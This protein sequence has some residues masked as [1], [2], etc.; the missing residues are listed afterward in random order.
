MSRQYKLGYCKNREDLEKHIDFLI[1]DLKSREKDISI[2]WN[3]SIYKIELKATI[4]PNEILSWEIVKH[5]RAREE[6]NEI[7]NK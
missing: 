4:E 5:Y 6:E 7:S 1:E 2:D 3:K